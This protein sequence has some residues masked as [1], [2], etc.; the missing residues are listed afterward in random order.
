MKNISYLCCIAILYFFVTYQHKAASAAVLMSTDLSDGYSLSVL[1]KISKHWQPPN[2]DIQR[3]I[4]IHIKID[5]KGNFLKCRNVSS[6]KATQIDEDICKAVRTIG[7]YGSPPYAIPVD[8][9]LSI[10]TGFPK[11]NPAANNINTQQAK[12]NNSVQSNL[13]VVL[14]GQKTANL[15]AVAV[16]ASSEDITAEEMANVTLSYES[17][18]A[19]EESLNDAM[20]L[21]NENVISEQELKGSSQISGV[22]ARQATATSGRAA[23]SGAIINGVWSESAEAQKAAL[24]GKKA[25]NSDVLTNTTLPSQRSE[26]LGIIVGKPDIIVKQ[27]GAGAKKS[28]AMAEKSSAGTEKSSAMAESTDAM[29]KK[30]SVRVADSH[31]SGN[32]LEKSLNDD[33]SLSNENAISGRELKGSSQVSGV[34]A[35]QATAT[36][37]RAAANGAIINGVWTEGAE[38]QKAVLAGKKAENSAVLTNATLPS[39]RAEKSS[40][41]TKSTEIM[42]EKSNAGV[43]DAYE[44]WEALEESLNDDKPLSKEKVISGHELKDSS[45]V[46]GVG[47]GQATATFGRAAASGAIINGV[48]TESSE[49]QKIALSGKMPENSKSIAGSSGGIAGSSGVMDVDSGL[50]GAGVFTDKSKNINSK[51]LSAGKVISEADGLYTRS[52]MKKIAPSLKLPENMNNGKYIIEMSMG[53]NAQGIVEQIS[54]KKIAGMQN[55][56]KTIIYA[57]KEIKDMPIPPDNKYQKLNLIFII[58]KR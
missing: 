3:N 52:V 26:N 48:W 19:L 13:S 1:E 35:R 8:V 5:G 30:S 16:S 22:G 23:A 40:T 14:S 2:D 44:P 53:I 7:E 47:A 15:D 31:E 9:Y 10:K 42:P 38:P 28:G 17:W 12:N 58:E 6:S 34:G 25:E 41:A 21:S 54:I 51:Q 36:F 45:Q 55:L 50:I 20:P 43:A 37:G 11:V 18:D 24:N 46:S 32:A 56:D 33:M 4:R 29:A 49:P 27:S 39:Q 57:I